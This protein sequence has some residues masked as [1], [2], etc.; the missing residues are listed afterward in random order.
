M[1][2]LQP[3]QAVFARRAYSVEIMTSRSILTE[4]KPPLIAMYFVKASMQA[5]VSPVV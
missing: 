3:D 1:P 2:M 4:K 5:A